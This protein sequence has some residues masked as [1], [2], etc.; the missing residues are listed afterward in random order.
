MDEL[1]IWNQLNN[2]N[3]Y[4]EIYFYTYQKNNFKKIANRSYGLRVL[5]LRVSIGLSMKEGKIL[6][7]REMNLPK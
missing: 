2:Y 7:I 6:W 3:L 4:Q 5:V 1:K